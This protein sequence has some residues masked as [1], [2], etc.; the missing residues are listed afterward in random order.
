MSEPTYWTKAV[1]H[2]RLADPILSDIIDENLRPFLSPNGN[3][4]NTLIKSIVG[5]QISVKAA[6]SV[7][8]QMEG[9]LGTVVPEN[10]VLYNLQ[11]LRGCGLS[12]RKSE[13]ILDFSRLWVDSLSDLDW[14]SMDGDG[15]RSRLLEIRGVG[16]WTVDM[17]MIFALG[18]PDILPLGDIGLIRAIEKTYAGGSNLGVEEIL[19]ISTGWSPYRTVATW[20]LWRVVD[21][22]PVNY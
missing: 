16:P 4:G 20:Y 15:V 12:M 10:I 7:W 14:F 21:P 1:K 9:L 19:D 8:R 5:Q 13:Y 2:L 18:Q 3:V 6:D 22:E 11:D 17:V